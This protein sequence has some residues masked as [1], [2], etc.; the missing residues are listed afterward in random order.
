M[1][2]GEPL[3]EAPGCAK[4]DGKGTRGRVAVHEVLTA[5]TRINRLTM[6]SAETHIIRDAA[7]ENGMIPMIGDGLEKL[8]SGLTLLDDVQRKIGIALA[9]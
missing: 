4:C 9:E 1:G 8:R 5:N 6:E 3:W 2:P 7:I